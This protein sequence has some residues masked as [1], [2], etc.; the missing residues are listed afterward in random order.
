MPKQRLKW[1]RRGET[2]PDCPARRWYID[3]GLQYCENGHQIQ[4]YVQYDVDSDDNFGETGKTARAQSGTDATEEK[5]E[6][7]PKKREV[8]SGDKAR[9]LFLECLQL[10]LRKELRWLVKER[11]FHRELES[12]CRDLW[13]LRIRGCPGLT[14]ARIQNEENQ[15]TEG[16]S[17][18]QE[19]R[20]RSRSVTQPRSPSEVGSDAN[21]AMHSSQVEAQTTTDGDKNKRESRSRSRTRLKSWSG[22]DYALPA[23]MDTL[24]IVYLGCLLRREPIRIGDIV[25]WARNN[26]MPFLGAN[27][28]VPESWVKRLPAWARRLLL[29]RYAKFNGSEL[30]EAVLDMIVNY[31]EHYNLVFPEINTPSVLLMWVRDLAVPL[32]VY[33]KVRDVCSNLQLVFS[34]PTD[35]RPMK[36]SG[37]PT[38]YGLLDLPDVLLAA[39]I[40][41]ATK[42]VA[43]L[44]DVKRLPQDD[45]DPLVIKWNWPVWETQFAETEKRPRTKLDFERIPSG[46]VWKMSKEDIEEYLSWLQETRINKERFA[47]GKTGFD[48]TLPLAKVPPLPVVKDMTR[49]EIM[50]RMKTVRKAAERVAPVPEDG[51]HAVYRMGDRHQAFKRAS[52]L[53]GRAKIFYEIVAAKAGLSLEDLVRAV[54]KFEKMIVRADKE[55]RR[56]QREEADEMDSCDLIH[57]KSD[58]YSFL[59]PQPPILSKT[60]LKKRKGIFVK[61]LTGKTITLEVESSDTIDNVKSKIQD[62]EGIPPDQQRLIFAGKQLEDGR[63][64]SDY[65]IQKESTLHLVL[66]LRGGI[67]EPSLKALAS[68][69][70]CDKM[71][72]RKCY[73]RL[74]PRATNCRKRKCGHTNQLRPKKKLK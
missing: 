57:D 64:L 17:Q 28:L 33:V 19:R 32:S 20:S 24:A 11:G 14:P 72:C 61:T 67:I 45:R 66:R 69:F 1:F 56:R 36:T 10:I 37:K 23:V 54:Y 2:C 65:N 74:P 25:R 52:E 73:A 35:G 4:G 27:Q 55:D 71:I 26:Q 12:V 29:T 3:N 59:S 43:P 18:S 62:K 63:T 60:P 46:D 38:R 9:E 58:H 41:F 13:N 22:R 48:R 70:N 50:A 31:K 40:V 51:K 30:H 49:E 6:I 8:L 34:F 5:D 42:L 44:D 16:G 47:N 15:E 7:R 68:K 39:S 21:S 53:R